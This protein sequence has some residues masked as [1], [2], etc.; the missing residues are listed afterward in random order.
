MSREIINVGTVP[1]DGTGDP[2]RTAYIKCNNN[3]AELYSRLQTEVPAS[4][5]GTAGDLAGMTAYDATYFY[6]CYQDYDG[7][8]DI[9]NRILGSSF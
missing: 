6:Y 2:L 8:S 1:N 3:F 5:L 7:S 4:S 9:W